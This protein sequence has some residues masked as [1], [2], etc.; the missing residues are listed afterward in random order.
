MIPKPADWGPEIDVTGFVFLDLASSFKPPDA[1]AEFLMGG[2]PPVYIGFGSIVVDDPQKFTKLIFDAVKMAGIRALVSEGWGGLG[3]KENTPDNIFM[4]GNTP[5]DWL[6]PKVRAVVHHGG[7]GTTAIGLKC[8]KPTMIVPFF[9]DQPFWGA[10][11]AKAGAGAEPIPYKKLTAEKL[12]ESIKILLSPEVQQCAEQ[13]A[14]NI[15]QEGDGAI[16]AVK[17]FHR[18]L[19]LRG[20]HSLRC[21][22]LE[23]YVAVWSLKKTHLRL[24]AV[25]ADILV[26]SGRLRWHD[27]RLLRHC[28]WNDFEGPGEPVTGATSAV[29]STVGRVMGG[30]GRIPFGWNR[31]IRKRRERDV[32]KKNDKVVPTGTSEGNSEAPAPV[33]KNPDQAE[34]GPQGIAQLLPKGNTMSGE[35]REG[36]SR[37]TT[38]G[39]PTVDG[40]NL[41]ESRKKRV[42]IEPASE[43]NIAQEIV[44]DAGDVI[45]ESGIAIAK[46]W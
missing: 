33:D 4:L 13:I 9:G 19:L 5:H 35:L 32:Q 18:S 27:L 3:D 43:E 6:F 36:R 25:A 16:N 37:L 38:Q 17:S 11:V 31:K 44:A 39:N 41:S 8:G 10:M 22:V 14:K 46:G 42:H 24:S 28:E 26:E 20:E 7:A 2:E 1:L 45:A 15:A 29:L 23:E 30:L 21:S 12:A 40:L 34:N